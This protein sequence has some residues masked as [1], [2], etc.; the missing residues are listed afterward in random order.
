[1]E[2]EQGHCTAAVVQ[3][4]GV[5]DQAD[6]FQAFGEGRLVLGQV[7]HA[8]RVLGQ[9][10]AQ[11]LQVFEAVFALVRAV[12]QGVEIAGLKQHG[13]EQVG[14]TVVAPGTLLFQP[15][16]EQCG[17]VGQRLLGA[18]GDGRRGCIGRHGSPE[19]LGC[20]LRAVVED[21]Q[22]DKLCFPQLAAPSRA[23][24]PRSLRRCRGRLVDDALQRHAV[25]G[26]GDEA[27]V[28]QRVFDFLRS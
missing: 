7:A 17:K 24:P 21:E 20:A 1:M 27:Q 6:L 11:F 23:A 28:G 10:A 22:R 2:G 15:A 18:A 9:H 25:G 19:H 4:V 5:G 14:D 12:A 3:V 8:G 26:V 13:V 16:F